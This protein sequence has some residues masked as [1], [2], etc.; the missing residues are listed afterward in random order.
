MRHAVRKQ[1]LKWTIIVFVLLAGVLFVGKLPY[2]QILRDEVRVRHMQL[3]KTA[4][5]LMQERLLQFVQDAY[6]LSLNASVKGYADTSSQAQREAMQRAMMNASNAYQHYDQIRYIDLQGQE[7]VRVDHADRGA[8]AIK[9][10]A[11][12]NKADRPYVKAGLKLKADEVYLSPIELNREHGAIERPFQPVIRL[13]RKV[14]DSRG[15]AQGLLVFN[16]AA[17]KLLH[18]FRALFPDLD[19]PM[20]LNSD[21]YWLLNPRP[22]Q[23]W[24]WLLGKPRQTLYAE[25]PELWQKVQATPEAMTELGGDLF[26]YRQ[27]T[28]TPL[29][30]QNL[31]SPDPVSTVLGH[32][33][34]PE[35]WVMLVQTRHAQWHVGAAYLRPWFRLFVIGL[36]AMA[37]MLVYFVITSRAQRRDA[38]KAERDQLM[39]FKDLYDNAPIGYIT[40]A[41]SGMITNVNYALLACLGY[42][43]E[44]LLNGRYLVNLVD[45]TSREA[46]EGLMDSL[47]AGEPDQYRM[48]MRCKSGELLAVLCSVSSRLSAASTL[49]IGRCSVQ[50]ISQQVSLERALERLAYTDSLT[51]LANRRHFNELAVRDAQRLQREGAPL[52]VLALDIDCFKSVNDTYGHAAGDEVLKALAEN[53][54]KL[55]RA[56]DVLA[57]MGGEEFGVLLPGATLEQGRAKAEALR[58]MLANA[59]VELASGEVV[60]YTVSVGVASL[61][62][63]AESRLPGLL[64]RADE[65]LYQAKRSGRNRV[66][67]AEAEG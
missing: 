34:T 35:P 4:N 49:T 26:S 41:A 24:G 36:F 64:K 59:P 67:V 21:G 44:E 40:L 13:V 30:A 42:Q 66:C 62:Q 53:G 15:E 60:G 63:P 7:Q 18:R 3:M 37:A 32:I 45:E 19:Q 47:G 25:R 10:A 29:K 2:D 52:T 39:A 31:K 54:G 56:S 28:F 20:L 14:T 1:Q 16:Y 48:Q 23:E 22:E 33:R 5:I 55:L 12:Q 43:R 61:A 51:G 38:R 17:D 50:D 65:A 6:H 57:R 58:R 46:L 11:L 8:Y 9:Q 27:L